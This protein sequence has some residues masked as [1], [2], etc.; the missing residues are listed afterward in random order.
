MFVV[1]LVVACF[2]EGVLQRLMGG[3]PASVLALGVV[4]SLIFVLNI[5]VRRRQAMAA[6]L[7]GACLTNFADDWRCRSCKQPLFGASLEEATATCVLCG[8]R[9]DA[10]EAAL[11]I[12]E[13]RPVPLAGE[14][15]DEDARYR[16][17]IEA[18]K[19]LKGPKNMLMTMLRVWA[20]AF[21]VVGV[22]LVL[23]YFFMKVV[24]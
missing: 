19:R 16:A 22:L 20:V 18:A 24:N 13:L 11:P 14:I 5:L 9:L 2:Q 12:E 4:P 6:Q 8:H 23:L 7:V 21:G 3:I 15:T 10:A 1:A 17:D